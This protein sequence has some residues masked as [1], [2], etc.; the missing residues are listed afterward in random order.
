MWPPPHMTS[1]A[2]T[3]P[4]ALPMLDEE[5]DPLQDY[6]FQALPGAWDPLSP[7]G[8]PWAKEAGMLPGC[9]GGFHEEDGG[10]AGP[11]AADAAPGPDAPVRASED[12]APRNATRA[13]CGATAM[14]A[15]AAPG[16]L[17]D[18]PR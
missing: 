5:G 8:A 18:A 4:G 17:P 13:D 3:A 14:A 10:G 6:S 9:D 11:G 12:G 16:V 2:T 7:T 15:T 1:D